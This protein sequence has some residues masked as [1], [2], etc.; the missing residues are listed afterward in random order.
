[1]KK[2]NRCDASNQLTKYFWVGSADECRQLF[3][4]HRFDII[5]SV[6]FGPDEGYV[7][8]LK[9]HIPMF[10]LSSLRDK[11]KVEQTRQTMITVIT[12][13]TEATRRK[14]TVFLHCQ[15]GQ[16]RSVS[17]AIAYIMITFGKSALDAQRYVFSRREVSR[18]KRELLAIAILVVEKKSVVRGGGNDEIFEMD[19]DG[20][21]TEDYIVE[22]M[23]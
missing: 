16:S 19:T 6:D 23:H 13:I 14:E 1:M 22:K 21:N 17:I 11:S 15:V 3:K 10:D 4:V 8:A 5:I 9:R 20:L 12:M 2:R 18:V 7:G